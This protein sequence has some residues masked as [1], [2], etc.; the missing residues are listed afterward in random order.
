[1]PMASVKN[2]DPISLKELHYSWAPK[3]TE[4]KD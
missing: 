1:M 2:R 4:V 3:V